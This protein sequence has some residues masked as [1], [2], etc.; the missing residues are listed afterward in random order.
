WVSAVT[1]EVRVASSRKAT[2]LV[3]K[4]IGYVIYED[5]GWHCA[6][7][8]LSV[9][10]PARWPLARCAAAGKSTCA[11]SSTSSTSSHLARWCWLKKAQMRS[12]ARRFFNEPNAVAFDLAV[13]GGGQLCA[14]SQP[15]DGAS[16]NEPSNGA[17]D[18]AVGRV[19]LCAISQ[20]VDRSKRQQG[21]SFDEPNSVAYDLAV[22]RGQLC[23]I[24]HRLDRAKRKQHAKRTSLELA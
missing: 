5:G 24:S 6:K 11:C 9:P 3:C 15:N 14:V 23:A 17:F 18:L 7:S 16:F 22:S 4:E 8:R 2:S 19:Q 21:A 20:R 12:A 1:T 13:G 10:A